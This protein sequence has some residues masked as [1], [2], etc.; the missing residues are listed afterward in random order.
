MTQDIY[1]LHHNRLGIAFMWKKPCSIMKEKVQIIF[2]DMGFYLTYS[3]VQR[4]QK[5]VQESRGKLP[6][7]GLG[8]GRNCRSL[9]LRTPSQKIDIAVSPGELEE[10]EDLIKGALFRVQLEDYLEKEGRN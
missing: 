7:C 8:C 5:L 6:D 4:F 10:I 2:R 9:L 1:I 3:E